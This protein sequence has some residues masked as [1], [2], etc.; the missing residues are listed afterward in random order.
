MPYKNKVL[1]ASAVYTSYHRN[2]Q[3]FGSLKCFILNLISLWKSVWFCD[4]SWPGYTFA[5]SLFCCW[6]FL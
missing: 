3:E 6:W 5:S 1:L 2:F 4:F